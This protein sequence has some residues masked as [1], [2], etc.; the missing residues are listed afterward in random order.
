[1]KSVISRF[2]RI[3]AGFGKPAV[4]LFLLLILSLVAAAYC[5]IEA[6]RK[7]D[8][9]H[10]LLDAVA[11]FRTVATRLVLDSVMPESES[12]V[13]DGIKRG[14]QLI[15]DL[16]GES[17][18]GLAPALPAILM[19]DLQPV[20][21]A[22]ENLVG[23]LQH[24]SVSAPDRQNADPDPGQLE[25][26]SGLSA[27]LGRLL[28]TIAVDESKKSAHAEFESLLNALH[29]TV[30][31]YQQNP[32]AADKQSLIERWQ[33][34]R[35]Q[36][37]PLTGVGDADADIL[38][39]EMQTEIERLD[40][41]FAVAEPA[42]D[43][44]QGALTHQYAKNSE[45]QL[46][47][48]KLRDAIKVLVREQNYLFRLGVVAALFSLLFLFILAIVFWRD[49]QNK[50]AM[51]MNKNAANQRAILRLLDEI[52]DLAEGDLTARAT[53]TE[54]IT[55]AIAD[56]VNYAI[57]TIRNL[58]VTIK[59]TSTRV[60]A[61][62]QETGQTAMRLSRAS[63]LQEREVRRSSNYITAMANTMRQMSEKSAEAK[64]IAVQSV[65][66][67]QSG[68]AAV[69]ETMAGMSDIRQQIQDT[70]KRLKRLGESSQQIGEIISLVNDIAERTNLLALNAAIQTS[71]A[72]G[73]N[74]FSPVADEV[75]KLAERVN[76]GTR[77]IEGLIVTIQAD[78][79]AAIA[80]MEKSTSG[81]VK[82]A[83]LAEQAGA[84]LNDIQLVSQQLSEKI[85]S[86]ADKAARQA[87]VTSK[88]SGNM[89]V[90]SDIAQQTN[91]G[92]KSTASSILELENM[93]RELMQEVSG[94]V[95]PAEDLENPETDT[96][97]P[98]GEVSASGSE[99]TAGEPEDRVRDD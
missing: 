95:L 82:G 54:D 26:L 66:N 25:T 48:D 14:N 20:S 8:N 23:S 73:Y 47:L 36:M 10:R 89:R 35:S 41:L 90:I 21:G 75:Q 85:Q 13:S 71:S 12:R 34:V 68:F 3:Q 62:A 79:R 81:V 40:P 56:S 76:E 32:L 67:A 42:A 46:L 80:S 83:S 29:E 92:M 55:G 2:G 51:S 94:F 9:N 33:A 6:N 37:Q 18:A 59:R 27:S 69:S 64:E 17:N 11:Q 30:V 45:L 86:I 31:D 58:V 57:D 93:S 28:A 22:W 91:E 74:K 7:T 5:F 97:R 60:A 19:P 72:G 53:V 88:L 38:L 4:I 24:A 52:T 78:T 44:V 49:S 63:G 15:G 39:S 77:E 16:A 50:I 84:S 70:S 61:A 65:L 43:I 98:I 87:E 99:E 96:A 1:M